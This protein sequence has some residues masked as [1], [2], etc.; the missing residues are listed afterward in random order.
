LGSNSKSTEAALRLGAPV[1]WRVP[2]D[3]APFY[4]ELHRM[5][6]RCRVRLL[7]N[8]R[9]DQL[10]LL[11]SD[12]RQLA[13]RL[14]QDGIDIARVTATVHGGGP[15]HNKRWRYW[16]SSW[17]HLCSRPPLF[18]FGTH[19]QFPMGFH[20]HRSTVTDQGWHWQVEFLTWSQPPARWH[21]QT[22]ARWGRGPEL[23]GLVPQTDSAARLGSS[24]PPVYRLYWNFYA[25]LPP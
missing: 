4:A 3:R 7:D 1:H 11:Y 18:P 19:W 14:S 16:Q 24:S 13:K 22:D 21:A 8:E 20:T 5:Q 15:P 25:K 23:R 10:V 12:A 17:A 9:I 6:Q 2:D